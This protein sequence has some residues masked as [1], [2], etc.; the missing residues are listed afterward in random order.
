MDEKLAQ[1]CS[2]VL[3]FCGDGIYP[4]FLKHMADAG[5]DE[6]EVEKLTEEVNA[7]AG[8]A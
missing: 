4:Q 2:T 6:A 8:R 5:Y 1:F 3:D 7:A